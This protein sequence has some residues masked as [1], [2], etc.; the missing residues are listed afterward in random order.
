[1]VR[2]GRDS[3][4]RFPLCHA[5]ISVQNLF[6]DNDL[7]ISCVID[8]ANAFTAPPAQLLA[9]PGLPRPGDLVSDSSLMDAFRSGFELKEANINVRSIEP[10]LWIA[11]QM[12]SRFVRLVT[13]D[14]FQD[15][16]HLEAL[17]TFACGS[18]TPSDED[19]ITSLPGLLTELA[20]EEDAMELAEDLA[21]EDVPESKIQRREK[22]YFELLGPERLAVA[23][24]VA[25]AAEMN[26]HFVADYRLWRWIDAVMEDRDMAGYNHT[27]TYADFRAPTVEI[28]NDFLTFSY[29]LSARKEWQ[30]EMKAREERKRR[31]EVKCAAF[32]ERVDRTIDAHA[33]TVIKGCRTIKKR[34]I[35]L[36]LRYKRDPV[37]LTGL[38]LKE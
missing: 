37:A 26:P 12:A 32:I 13:L 15:Y 18:A 21:A 3:M 17:W 27:G 19:D 11:G 10:D 4:P 16:V 35:A 23:Q 28:L 22:E 7:N 34:M 5:D 9:L 1:M 8:W 2:H 38:A 14:A 30:E 29:S 31:F 20:E 36:E 6:V 33:H 25:L 24:K